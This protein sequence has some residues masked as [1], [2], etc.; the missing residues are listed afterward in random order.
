[1]QRIKALAKLIAVNFLVLLVL[2]FAAN[3]LL[4]VYL[5]SSQ[6]SRADLPNYTEDREIAKEIFSDYGRISHEYAPFIGWKTLPYNGNTLTIGE[7]GFRVVPGT[8]KSTSKRLKVGFFGGSTMWGEGS[9]DSGT[10]PAQFALLNPDLE[11]YN[12]GQLAFNSRQNL[13]MLTNLYSR[14][15]HLDIVIFYDGVNDAAFLCPDKIS[16]PG[17]RMEPV[18]KERL[19]SGNMFLI[20]KALYKYFVQ[21]IVNFTN[22][23]REEYL[24]QKVLSEYQCYRNESKINDIADGMLNNWR[25]ASQMVSSNGGNFLG[26]LQP[27]AYRG[28]PVLDH[29]K[30]LDPELGESMSMVYTKVLEKMDSTYSP[31][32]LNLTGAFDR[33]EYIYIDFCHVSPNGNKIVSDKLNEFIHKETD[34]LDN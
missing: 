7:D 14:G 25:L 31:V 21:N 3:F 20:R 10:I 24:G 2:L 6:P 28:R 13:A 29:L 11:V 32:T 16:V 5:K 4:G 9:T 34:W 19:Y 1:M 17:H 26:I 12:F 22:R 15:I 30:N 33:E 18:F 8:P 27:M 23:I